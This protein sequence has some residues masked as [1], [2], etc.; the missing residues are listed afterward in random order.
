M[1][2]RTVDEVVAMASRMI[3]EARKKL[4]AR[5]RQKK[6]DLE[7]NLDSFNPSELGQ[8][9]RKLETMDEQVDIDVES[10]LE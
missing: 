5:L 2:P 9:A 1:M 3:P 4:V 10:I 8:I 6:A 7:L